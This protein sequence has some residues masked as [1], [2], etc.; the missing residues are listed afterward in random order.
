MGGVAIYLG[1]VK[2]MTVVWLFVS[3]TMAKS[4]NTPQ[5]HATME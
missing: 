5:H 3:V 1:G 4:M 2:E